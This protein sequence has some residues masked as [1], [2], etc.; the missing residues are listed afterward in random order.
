[1][2]FTYLHSLMVEKVYS[3]N[4]TQKDY[5]IIMSINYY[6]GKTQYQREFLMDFDTFDVTRPGG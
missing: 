1:M 6:Q 4:I 3:I 5:S 2:T